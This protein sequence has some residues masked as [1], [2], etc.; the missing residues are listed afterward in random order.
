MDSKNSAKIMITF[1]IGALIAG[2]FLLFSNNIAVGI[3]GSVSS[4]ALIYKGYQDLKA[5]ILMK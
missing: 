2:V 5:N 4:L 3:G 1:G